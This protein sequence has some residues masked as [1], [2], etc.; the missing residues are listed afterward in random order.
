[1]L[2]QSGEFSGGGKSRN[3]SMDQ[4]ARMYAQ[5]HDTDPDDQEIRAVVTDLLIAFDTA[6]DRLPVRSRALRGALLR[7]R[8]EL[9]RQTD[10]PQ[11]GLR[12]ADE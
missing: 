5:H 9:A 4:H 12:A 8:A 10:L 7:V 3:G 11:R 1:M 2:E 6:I